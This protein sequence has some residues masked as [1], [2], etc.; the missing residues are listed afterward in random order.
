MAQHYLATMFG[1]GAREMQARAGSRAAYARM[2]GAADGDVDLL[3]EREASF[4]GARDS[5]YM[6]STTEGGWPYMQHRGGPAGFLKMLGG[7]RIGFGDL[8]GN[9]QY[10]SAANLLHDNRVA[11]FLMDYPAKR[12][13][14]M[15]GH[16]AIIDAA[17]DPLLAAR[18]AVDGGKA[19]VERSFVI[20]VT[21]FDWNCPQYITPRFTEAEIAAATAPLHDE[22][23]MLRATVARLQEQNQGRAN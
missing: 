20:E 14:K 23:T 7:N 5:F 18:L 6:A 22:I 8:G 1:P 16:A 9:R 21:A 11:L 17:D 19:V 12:R 10:L 3:G 2:E 4:I 13:L 15:I